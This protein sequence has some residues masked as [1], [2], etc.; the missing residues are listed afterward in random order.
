MGT[1]MA[2][3]M[4]K[5]MTENPLTAH[6]GMRFPSSTPMT[7]PALQQGMAAHIAPI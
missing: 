7:V 1:M 5:S 2:M 6:T 4:P 3:N